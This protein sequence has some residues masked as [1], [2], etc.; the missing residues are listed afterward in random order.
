M[1]RKKKNIDPFYA[2]EAKKYKKPIASREFIIQYL[3]KLGTP[4]R[5]SKLVKDFNL[6]SKRLQDAL[7]RRLI[8]MVRDG[9]LLTDRKGRY[10]LVKQMGML[11]GYVIC[12]KDGYGFL[13]PDDGSS[14][15]RC[16][17]G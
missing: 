4:E 17:P 5:Y 2:R 11:Q 1:P 6:K 16:P 8:A 7:R 10:A 15:F 13:V 9:Q 12:H 14:D 3:E